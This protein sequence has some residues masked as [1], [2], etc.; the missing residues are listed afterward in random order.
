MSNRDK[1]IQELLKVIT[2]NN[3]DSMKAIK[4]ASI[5]E[6]YAD[7]LFGDTEY[8]KNKIKS[9]NDNRRKNFLLSLNRK[10]NEKDLLLTWQQGIKAKRQS[11]KLSLS[12]VGTHLSVTKQSVHK[13]EMCISKI[14]VKKALLLADLL[15]Y[16]MNIK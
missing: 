15:N 5:A 2:S 9:I 14:P 10:K 13:W 16:P 1:L 12:D 6:E 4:C 11:S 3:V 8:V 7:S